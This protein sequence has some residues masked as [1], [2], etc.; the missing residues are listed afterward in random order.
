MFC[1]KTLS[2]FLW[3][4]SLTIKISKEFYWFVKPTKKYKIDTRVRT[5]NE[6]II[7]NRFI[8]IYE[9]TKFIVFF[10]F[11]FWEKIQ[12][13][14]IFKWES[15]VVIIQ[16]VSKMNKNHGYYPLLHSNVGHFLS[17][18]CLW[19][20]K[21]GGFLGQCSSLVGKSKYCIFLIKL[22]KLVFT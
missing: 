3:F 21:K 15:N 17:V 22:S 19:D 4:E 16:K 6:S 13:I 14:M 7:T 20:Y 18:Y 2:W 8:P 9:Y 10:K 5:L 11:F 12:K 1:I